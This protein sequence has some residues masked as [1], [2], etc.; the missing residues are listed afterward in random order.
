MSSKEAQAGIKINQLLEQSGWR[1]FDNEHGNP[2]PISRFQMKIR[3]DKFANQ[4][5]NF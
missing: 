5:L 2:S 3:I 4:S 1:F